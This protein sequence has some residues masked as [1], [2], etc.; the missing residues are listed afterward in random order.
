MEPERE[1]IV[2]VGAGIV[3]VAT[4]YFTAKKLA[5]KYP[6]ETRPQVILLE[7]C[8]PGC[9][10]S[11]KSGGFLARHWSDGTDTEQLAQ[12]SYDL[13]AKL[14]L[15]HNGSE[16]W[17]YRPLNTFCAEIDRIPV[18]PA[19]QHKSAH[20]RTEAESVVTSIEVIAP[21]AHSSSSVTTMEYSG[22]GTPVTLFDSENQQT[23]THGSISVPDVGGVKEVAPEAVPWLKTSL[24]NKLRQVGDTTSTAQV[25]PL[26][27]TRSLLAEAKGYGLKS[28][29]GKVIDVADTGYRQPIIEL[30]IDKGAGIGTL[31]ELSDVLNYVDPSNAES[32]SA[33]SKRLGTTKPYILLL[34]QGQDIPA[35]KI[36]VACGAWA[37][38]CLR[39]EAFRDV[40]AS[41]IPIQGLRVHYLLAKPKEQ[42]PA[43]AVFAEIN[44]TVYSGEDA[45]EI[46]PRPDGSVFIC[47]EALDDPEMPPHNPFEPVYS[48]R[49]TGRLKQIVNDVSSTLSFDMIQYG[50]ACHLPVHAKG[51]PVISKVPSSKG[52]YIAAGHGCWGILNGPATGL[53]ISELLVDDECSRSQH[54]S[55]TKHK[56]NVQK[57]LRKIGKDA[58][59]KVQAEK[60][61]NAQLAKIE[62]AAAQS[63]SKDTGTTVLEPAAVAKQAASKSAKP[64]QK[65]DQTG[66]PNEPASEPKQNNR[67]AN[68]GVIGEWEVV[69]EIVDLPKSDRGGGNAIDENSDDLPQNPP[70][71]RGAE[72]LDEEDHHSGQLAD[73]DIKEKTATT[74]PDPAD[75]TIDPAAVVFKKRRAPVNR[76]TRKQRKL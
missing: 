27:F 71:L 6:A 13:H 11:G 40:S 55:G 41:Q 37:T 76:S 1:T 16:R 38:S 67:P 58:E 54:E 65:A 63:Y 50:L 75:D 73:F 7:Q 14:A 62:A 34:D 4:A 61:L 51:I 30:S 59:A 31:G 49:A 45:I 9:S 10:A 2:I 46:Y 17:G 22:P 32:I 39:W 25:D 26:K 44:G 20:Q 69:E 3:G 24:V 18:M 33:K 35:D 42:I 8:E 29:R 19:K 15:E 68:I 70:E 56:E 21:R 43:Q 52:L 74:A 23:S 57:F 60:Q 66:Q 36:V 12:F 64:A 48:K 47:G 72:L 53:A 28:I 5:K